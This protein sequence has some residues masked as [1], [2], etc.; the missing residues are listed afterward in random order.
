[1]NLSSRQLTENTWKNGIKSKG[2]WIL[3]KLA[4]VPVNWFLVCGG[5]TV[6]I[7]VLFLCSYMRRKLYSINRYSEFIMSSIEKPKFPALYLVHNR[8]N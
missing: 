3:F 1:M 4:G 7:I 8:P 2:K 5:S 6:T